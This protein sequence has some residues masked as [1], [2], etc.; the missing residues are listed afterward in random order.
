L[1]GTEAYNQLQ[2]LQQ[3]K[4]SLEMELQTH[5]EDMLY[6]QKY[7]N[8]ILDLKKMTKESKKIISSL[9]IQL[10]NVTNRAD[11]S[12]LRKQYEET[13]IESMMNTYR[14]KANSANQKT[15]QAENRI[16]SL[17]TELENSI[18]LEKENDQLSTLL[19]E[20]NVKL[21]KYVENE[22][23]MKAT[24]NVLA[25]ENIKL[26]K[27]IDG[28]QQYYT[29][30]LQ[31]N[32]EKEIE[33]IQR[34]K[35]WNRKEKQIER[36]V[37]DKYS[38]K[39]KKVEMKYKDQILQLKNDH[40]NDLEDLTKRISIQYDAKMKSTRSKYELKINTLN[41]LININIKKWNVERNSLEMKI[42]TEHDVSM[43]F[44]FVFVV[45]SLL[46]V[47]IQYFFSTF[48]PLP[49]FFFSL[50]YCIPLYSSILT[51]TTLPK[52]SV[53]LLT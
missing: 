24:N 4:D 27:T 1:D 18:F 5:A 40:V 22:V 28:Q 38:M 19:S 44:V 49:F 9:E 37:E 30:I 10:M 50:F 51:N 23:K 52:H 6:V 15:E 20:M 31:S 12:A 34:E 2:A 39:M 11:E 43:S 26:Q 14:E 33:L 21:K 42:R 8:E 35:L 29:N 46:L 36:I 25:V 13:E 3:E 7:K 48:I 53:L 41:E 32:N 45:A 16:A 47:L 17:V